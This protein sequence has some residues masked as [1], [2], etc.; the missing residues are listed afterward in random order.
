MNN[1]CASSRQVWSQ[2]CKPKILLAILP[3]LTFLLA[4]ANES[5]QH[6]W[7]CHLCGQEFSR[8]SIL[9]DHLNVHDDKKPHICH[10]CDTAFARRS[11]WK[12]HQSKHT[13]Q[14][15]RICEKC[16]KSFTRTDSYKKHVR[17]YHEENVFSKSA[18]PEVKLSPSST[19][20]DEETVPLDTKPID[21][22][23][24]TGT[25]YPEGQLRFKWD[26]MDIIDSF[27]LDESFLT[28]DLL[29]VHDLKLQCTVCQ[30]NLSNPQDLKEHL[31][32]HLSDANGATEHVCHSC[33]MTFRYLFQLA[34]HEEAV[35]RLAKGE[36]GNIGCDYCGEAFGDLC[37]INHATLWI[38]LVCGANPQSSTCQKKR[39]LQDITLKSQLELQ[40]KEILLT[41]DEV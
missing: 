34:A 18:A 11:D 32:E 26:F 25:F 24:Q 30:Q 23:S 10:I 7:S 1:N 9:Q 20:S 12:R 31:E 35:K 21:S 37:V 16:Q 5:P 4:C 27:S 8:K 6:R 39:A 36:S 2:T 29:G 41:C 19:S 14:R 28:G 17:H 33:N 40:I 15:K 22:V 13:H 3:T 38:H